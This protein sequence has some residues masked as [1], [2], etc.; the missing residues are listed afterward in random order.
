VLKWCGGAVSL[1]KI[2]SGFCVFPSTRREREKESAAN[3]VRMKGEQVR[4]C[5]AVRLHFRQ[6]V[7]AN[8]K[9]AGVCEEGVSFAGSDVK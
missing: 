7:E 6:S 1:H 5:R 2:R 8:W 9:Q 4:Q 3:T